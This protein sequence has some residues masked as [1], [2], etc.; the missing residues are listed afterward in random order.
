MRPWTKLAAAIFALISLLHLLRLVF[1]V[2]V[3]VDGIAIPVWISVLGCLVS[4]TLAAMVWRESG[5]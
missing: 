2:P 4:G 3:F 1:R 5:R